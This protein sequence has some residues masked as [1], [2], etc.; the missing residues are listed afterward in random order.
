MNANQ[1]QT[2]FP[3]RIQNRDDMQ[4]LYDRALGRLISIIFRRSHAYIGRQLEPWGLSRGQYMFLAQL[5]FEDGLTQDEI[6]RRLLVDKGTTARAIASLES[7]G[8]VRRI[9]D[10]T[11]RR[12]KIVVLQPRALEIRDEFFGIVLD[13]NRRLV[14]GFTPEEFDTFINMLQRVS[15]NAEQLNRETGGVPL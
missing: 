11:D 14:D 8:L 6:S 5:Y 2:I 9:G 12:K 4:Q 7:Q 1:T 10:C 3:P 13:F 15:D